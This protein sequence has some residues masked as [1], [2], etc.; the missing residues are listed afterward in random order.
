MRSSPISW[1]HEAFEFFAV[2]LLALS[3]EDASSFFRM[4]LFIPP[5]SASIKGS[6]S[7]V[8]GMFVS[9]AAGG[10]QLRLCTE[11]FH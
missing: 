1:R 5:V 10:A 6:D 7:G 9:C 2:S 4:K 11:L 3:C 8:E